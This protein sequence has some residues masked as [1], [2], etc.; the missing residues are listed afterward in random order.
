MKVAC[1]NFLHIIEI[2]LTPPFTNGKVERFFSRMEPYEN[3]EGINW[4]KK[5]WEIQ[6]RVGE[7]GVNI[8]QFNPNP[9]I[10]KGL[11]LKCDNSTIPNFVTI[12]LRK[13]SLLLDLLHI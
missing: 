11:N 8:E 6:L 12:I 5:D 13:E 7:E 3:T 9:Y 4:V 1:S 10:K 2:L